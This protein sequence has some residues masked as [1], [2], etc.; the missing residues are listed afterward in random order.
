MCLGVPAVVIDINEDSCIVKVD[1]GDG[2]VRETLLGI[3]D[4]KIARGDVVMVHAGVII[5]KLSIEGLYEQI[6][7]IRQLLND[8][9]NN[10]ASEGLVQL[11]Q[12]IQNIIQLTKRFKAK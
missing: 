11:Y 7:F 8:V 2:I 12:N 9:E 10:Q 6:E 3:S 4:E 5:S 1:Y